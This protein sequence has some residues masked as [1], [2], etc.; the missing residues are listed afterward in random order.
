MKSKGTEGTSLTKVREVILFGRFLRASVVAMAVFALAFVL[1]PYIVAEANATTATTDVSWENISLTLDPD[2]VATQGGESPDLATHGNVE[3]GNVVPTAK[4][5]TGLAYGTQKVAKKTIRV[6]TSGNYYAVYLSTNSTS[7]NDLDIDANDSDQKIDAINDGTNEATFG[8]A[9]AFTGTGWGYAVPGTSVSGADAAFTTKDSSQK[10]A[11]EYYDN[12]LAGTSDDNLTKTGT[13]SSFY[14]TGKWAAVPKKDA[15][16]QIWK[17]NNASGF[18]GG[19]TFDVYY[20]IMVDTD[21]VSGTYKNNIVYTAMASTQNLDSASTNMSRS[22]EFVT[23]GT[24]ETLKIDL[25]SSNDTIETGDVKVYLVPHSTFVNNSY[26]VS[27]LDTSIYNQCAVSAVTSANGAATITCTMPDVGD[28][29]KDENSNPVTGGDVIAIAGDN[30]ALANTSASVTGEYDFWVKVS[31]YGNQYFD[32]VSHY[33]NTG[34]VASVVYAGLQSKET[35]TRGGQGYI[36]TMQEMEANICKNTNKWG[37]TY[38]TDARVYDYTGTGT[39]LANTAA[40]SAAIGV[41]TFMLGDN[42]ETVTYAKGTEGYKR[43][44]GDNEVASVNGDKLYLIRRFAD[45]N[46]WMVQNLDLNLADFTSNKSKRLTSENTNI[47]DA[48]WIPDKTLSDAGGMGNPSGT[49]YLEPGVNTTVAGTLAIGT[50]QFQNRLNFGPNL[51]WGSRYTNGTTTDNTGTANNNGLVIANNQNSDYPR[52]YNN[53][54]GYITG[55]SNTRDPS[56]CAAIEGNSGVW[57]SKCQMPGSI[58]NSSGSKDLVT[59]TS[60][61]LTQDST[62]QPSYISTSD[63][64]TFTMRGSMYIGDYYNWYA[65][66]AG[67]GRYDMSNSTSHNGAVASHSI[68]PKGWKLPVN[69]DSSVDGSWQHLINGTYGYVTTN[70]YNQNNRAALNKIMQLPLSIP[71]AGYYEWTNGA[72]NSRGNVGNYWSSTATSASASTNSYNLNMNYGGNVNPQN[73]NNK[74]NGLTIRCIAE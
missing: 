13:G 52:S 57:D 48:Q 61:G 68:C 32:Y 20:S 27:S 51:Y 71:F 26:S 23:S 65:A 72:L 29:P 55:T 1:V 17:A 46:C 3:F 43:N 24:V 39:A 70:G 60:D 56:G 5:T 25:I 47:S 4:D 45:G 63:G 16:Q 66:T 35:S 62:W 33:T 30:S 11:Y 64:A 7:S 10:Y 9:Q 53:D 54:L 15:A 44:G 38:G 21:V 69:G 74:V 2:W 37:T 41:G 14:N 49:G 42:R 73:N 6:V 36:T 18:N 22:V 50:Y 67:S 40:G 34:V 58:G 12:N 19:S 8:S 31:K 28:Y 59:Q